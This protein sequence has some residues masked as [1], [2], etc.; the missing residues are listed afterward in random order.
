MLKMDNTHRQGQRQH[1]SLKITNNV[2]TTHMTQLQQE[3]DIMSFIKL[4]LM[5]AILQLLV[6]KTNTLKMH[7]LV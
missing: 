4:A 2:I 3:L 1:H 6:F 7:Y 5:S